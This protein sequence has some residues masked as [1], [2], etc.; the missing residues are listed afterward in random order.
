MHRPIGLS[1]L[2]LRPLVTFSSYCVYLSKVDSC[3]FSSSLLSV[4]GLPAVTDRC[5]V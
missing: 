3:T 2:T 1:A 4:L 5:V